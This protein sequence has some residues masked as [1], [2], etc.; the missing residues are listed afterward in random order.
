M[1]SRSRKSLAGHRSRRAIDACPQAV[2]VNVFD[3]RR[4]IREK[5]VGQNVASVI[6]GRTDGSVEVDAIVLAQVFFIVLAEDAFVLG[7]IHP[8]PAIINADELEANVS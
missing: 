1:V 4:H 8:H 2:G 6:A 3:K 5:P 7:R